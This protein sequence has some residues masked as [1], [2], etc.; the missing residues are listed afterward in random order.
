MRTT[1]TF[2]SENQTSNGLSDEERRALRAMLDPLPFAAVLLASDGRFVTTN[3]LFDQQWGGLAPLAGDRAIG[4]IVAEEDLPALATTFAALSRGEQSVPVTLE[5]RFPAGEAGMQSGLAGF[6]AYDHGSV[7]LIFMQVA[8]LDAQVAREAALA[9]LEKRSQHALTASKLGVWD[10]NFRTGVFEF[11]DLWLSIR[12]FISPEELVHNSDQWIQQVHPDDR[13]AT[14][15][16]I[17]RQNRGDPDYSVFRYRI[18]HKNGDWIWIECR[19]MCVEWD[20]DGNP[21]RATGTDADVTSRK[22]WE[23][24][25]T[26]LSQRLRLALDISRIGVFEANLTTGMTNWDERMYD[27]YGLPRDEKIQVGS[28]WEAM[29]HPDDRERVLNKMSHHLEHLLP[30]SDEFRVIRRDGSI[31]YIRSRSVPFIEM[32]TGHRKVVGADW[33]VSEDVELQRQLRQARDLAEARNDALEAARASIEHNALHD[34]LTGLPNRRYLDCVLDGI[35]D[36]RPLSI[37]HIDLDRF[38]QINDTQGH[39]VGDAM[40]KHAAAILADCAEQGDFIARIG[41]DEFVVVARSQGPHDHLVSLADRIINEL[42]KPVSIDGN[43]CRIGAS[44][45]I[46][47]RISGA[48]NARQLL[49]NADI[50]LYRAKNL[51]RNRYE[52]FSSGMQHEIVNTKKVSDEILRGLEN[53]EFEP[54]YQFQF[55]A[56]TLDIR[57]AETLARWRHPERGILTPDRFLPIAEDLDAVAAIDAQILEKGL[58]DFH[59]WQAEGL[60]VPKISVNVSARRLHDPNLHRSVR[61]LGIAPGTVSFELLESIFL[62]N[63]DATVA[64]NLQNLRA[65]GIDIEIDDFGSGHASIVSLVKLAPRTLKIDRELIMPL[66]N[67]PEQRKLVGSIIDIGRSLNIR[68][69]AE[70]VETAEHIRILRELGCDKLQGYA[71]AR[72]IPMEEV[73]AFIRSEAWRSADQL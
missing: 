4:E 23:D 61:Q 27:I 71:L 42:R 47:N 15:Y 32:S 66:P 73:A 18:R 13:D 8:P 54:F 67:S 56:R 44:I 1:T 12:G 72:P 6:T 22:D 70:G 53:G 19:G 14:L 30:H 68:V 63:F 9:A 55:D 38:K 7:P 45:G 2:V 51:G 58:A 64:D 31:G 5:L 57:G 65:L 43:Q 36:E 50:A 24:N 21:L 39:S 62:D 20:E 34:H 33:D 25:M 11:S 35:D 60:N 40:L 48:P 17:E 46:A 10:H 26:A 3:P 49:Q 29:L 59:R 52:I 69:V 41:G 16:A 37:L 28:V